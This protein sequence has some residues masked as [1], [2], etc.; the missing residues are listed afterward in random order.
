MGFANAEISVIFMHTIE[1]IILHSNFQTNVKTERIL[2]PSLEIWMQNYS[3]NDSNVTL[4]PTSTGSYTHPFVHPTKK[5]KE[6][7]VMTRKSCKR[8]H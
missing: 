8:R 2:R 3:F 1:G 5:N 4:M 6:I 7:M